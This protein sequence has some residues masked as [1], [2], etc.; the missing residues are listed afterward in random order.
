MVISIE[1]LLFVTSLLS[2]KFVKKETTIGM[3]KRVRRSAPEVRAMECLDACKRRLTDGVYVTLANKLK[4][5]HDT[6]LQI[7]ALNE[8]RRRREHDNRRRQAALRQHEMIAMQDRRK[9]EHWKAVKCEANELL[10]MHRD[11]RAY[12]RATD[13]L[14]C[15]NASL[16]AKMTLYTAMQSMRQAE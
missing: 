5:V 10:R 6:R 4:K 2:H 15:E 11:R 13:K 1:S 12:A 3:G 9:Y 8:L 7:Q 16:V 14:Q